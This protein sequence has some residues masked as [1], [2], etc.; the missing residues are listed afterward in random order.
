MLR[1]HEPR[2][3]SPMVPLPSIAIKAG[4]CTSM[5]L[6]SRQQAVLPN[7]QYL[8]RRGKRARLPVLTEDGPT[9]VFHK[10]AFTD[11]SVNRHRAVAEH[12]VSN[13][14]RHSWARINDWLN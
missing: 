3:L 2:R 6:E 11:H 4:E 8:R 1:T 10:R 13:L 14:A 9:P 5:R 7:D 12:S